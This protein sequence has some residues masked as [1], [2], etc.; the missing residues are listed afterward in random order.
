MLILVLYV[1]DL[2]ITNDDK[3]I[4]KC[5]NDLTSEFEMTDL[6]LMHYFLGLEIWKKSDEINLS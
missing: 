3:L 6:G 5:E 1:D 2:F 4:D